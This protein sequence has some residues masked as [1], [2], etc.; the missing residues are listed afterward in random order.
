MKFLCDNCRASMIGSPKHLDAFWTRAITDAR[1]HTQANQFDNA[2]MYY[3]NALDASELLL[4]N[5][6]FC[7]LS[8]DKYIRTGMELLFALRK[9]GYLND[10]DPFIDRVRK[11]LSKK[12]LSLD[13]E[14][15]LQPLRDVA[16][17]PICAVDIWMSTLV[18]EK[19]YSLSA[20]CH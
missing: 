17:N 9:G 7:Q 3:G 19:T 20:A 12:A 6:A 5:S 16:D 2:I 11:C 10:L 18:T 4:S 14:W 15:Y 13:I 1:K 8:M